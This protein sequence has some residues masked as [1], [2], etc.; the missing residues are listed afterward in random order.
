MSSSARVAVVIVNWNSGKYLNR[1]LTALSCQ[2]RLPDRTILVDNASTDGSCTLVERLFPTV[3]V[4]RLKENTGFAAGN[5]RAVERAGDCEW[6]A[7]LNPDA[8]PEPAWLA[9]LME[10]AD[11]SFPEFSMFASHLLRHGAED[12]LDGTGDV[13]H[14]SGLAWRRDHGVK[15]ESVTRERGEVFAPCAAAALVRREEFVEAGGFDETFFCYFE[16]VD[17]AF[18]LRL[19]GKRCLYVP[20]AVVSHVG[21]GTTRRNSDFSVYHG[22]RNLV[23]CYIQNMPGTLFWVFLP[24]HLLANLAALVWFS[25][26]GQMGPVFRA[27]WS[28]LLGLP[29]AINR[30]KSVQEGRRVR[31]GV[32]RRAMAR[33]WWLPYTSSRRRR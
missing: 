5:N 24:Q 3:E 22:H 30:R 23:W 13:Y 31:P 2:S 32:L 6:I 33:G 4:I 25:I 28:A 16:D 8:F 21:S 20:G 1:C 14:V 27:K 11:R 10:A 9:A 18:R 17:L 29:R 7:F 15:G 19:M 26:R 12:E